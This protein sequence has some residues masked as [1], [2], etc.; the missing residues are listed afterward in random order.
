MALHSVSSSVLRRSM[1]WAIL[2]LAI[3]MTGCASFRSAS[4]SDAKP[5]LDGPTC[6]LVYR[7]K[8]EEV[9][10]VKVPLDGAVTVGRLLEESNVLAQR[11]RNKVIIYR[12]TDH[13]DPLRLEIELESRKKVKEEFNYALQPDDQIIVAPDTTSPIDHLVKGLGPLGRGR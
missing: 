3:S 8:K 1:F 11:R 5:A 9:K 10:A 7:D 2:G 12:K 6:T 13:P 4:P